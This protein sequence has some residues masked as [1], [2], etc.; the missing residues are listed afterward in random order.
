MSYVESRIDYGLFIWVFTTDVR[1][2][3]IDLAKRLKQDRMR[4]MRLLL[5][6]FQQLNVSF[7]LHPI[8]W[9]MMSLSILKYMGMIWWVL[10]PWL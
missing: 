9:A 8:I 3:R 1:V 5:G 6:V 7:T 4:T 2:N 10:K